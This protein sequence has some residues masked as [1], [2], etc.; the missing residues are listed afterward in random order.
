[1][2]SWM[3]NRPTLEQEQATLFFLLGAAILLSR[4]SLIDDDLYGLPTW[5]ALLSGFAQLLLG[6]G[7]W[8]A[9]YKQS[10]FWRHIFSTAAAIIWFSFIGLYLSGPYHQIGA[11]TCGVFA[12]FRICD[13]IWLW[14]QEKR[15]E[16]T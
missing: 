11:V 12:L 16:G 4:G 3:Y 8:L 2:H 9:I 7:Y 14:Q 15:W 10:F 5:K 6:I 1:M 13:N